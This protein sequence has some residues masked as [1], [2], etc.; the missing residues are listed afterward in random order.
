MGMASCRR[1]DTY[2]CARGA[3]G[4]R[5]TENWEDGMVGGN[6]G[7]PRTPESP[8]ILVNDNA[9]I[10]G[11]SIWSMRSL[12]ILHA[13]SPAFRE[14]GCEIG[15]RARV[16]LS[17]RGA[18]AELFPLIRGLPWKAFIFRTVQDC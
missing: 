16:D 9:S 2:K 13:L 17:P 18:R 11:G 1:L 15:N 5:L 10:R 3:K 12:R 14:Q 8:I 7:G 4:A 6:G